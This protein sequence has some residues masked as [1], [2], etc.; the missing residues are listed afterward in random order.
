MSVMQIPGNKCKVCGRNIVL[1]SEGE[2]CRE[3]KSFAHEACEPG[4][5]CSVCGK[6]LERYKGPEADP[7]RDAIVPRSLRPVGSGAA[8]LAIGLVLLVALGVYLFISVAS[9]D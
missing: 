5:V 7:M 2:Y 8:A 9:S 1:S 4:D 6:P 3:C